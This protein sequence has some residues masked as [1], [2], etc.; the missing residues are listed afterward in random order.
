MGPP[1]SARGPFPHA[2]EGLEPSG[3]SNAVLWFRGPQSSHAFALSPCPS[4]GC[5]CRKTTE[6]V[7]RLLLAEET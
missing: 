7:H 6:L 3:C 5:I 4:D 2:P 1:G